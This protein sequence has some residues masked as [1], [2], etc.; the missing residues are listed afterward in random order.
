M[1]EGLKNLA[2]IGDLM[3]RAK[4]VQEQMKKVQEELVQ[5]RVSGDS[6]GGMVTATVNGRMEL[7]SLKI[8]KTRFDASDTEML[9]DLIV[10]AVHAAQGKAVDAGREHMQKAA[11]DLGLPPGM[12]P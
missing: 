5:L 10:A 7:V 11:A 4:D 9:E 2:N 12:L 8:D 1:F 3:R 6:G